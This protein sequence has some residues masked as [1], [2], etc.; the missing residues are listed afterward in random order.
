MDVVFTLEQCSFDE[1]TSVAGRTDAFVQLVTKQ[2]GLEASM[3]NVSTMR[4][5]TAGSCQFLAPSTVTS[6]LAFS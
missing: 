4:L 3:L 6:A 1:W 2:A 5:T